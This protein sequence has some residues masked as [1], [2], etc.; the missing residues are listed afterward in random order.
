[1]PETVDNKLRKRE[2]L[3]S[4]KAIGGLFKSGKVLKCYPLKAV[5]A[6]C[7]YNES[8]VKIVVSVPKKIHKRAV[9]R[10]YI[11]RRIKEAYRLNKNILYE[12]L[13]NK[14][15]TLNIMLIYI[16]PAITDYAGIEKK[17]KQ[18]LQTLAESIKENPDIY[19]CN[20]D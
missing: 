9:K 18:V 5:Y 12:V 19:T 20:P 14:Q 3:C 13:Q 10:N 16:S 17:V 6:Y 7:S 8:P 15:C 11:R 2:R 1:L 4:Q